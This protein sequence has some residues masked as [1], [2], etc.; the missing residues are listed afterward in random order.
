ML[1]MLDRKA[2]EDPTRRTGPDWAARFLLHAKQAPGRC[3]AVTSLGKAWLP[4]LLGLLTCALVAVAQSEYGAGVTPDGA[5]YYQQSYYYSD[6]LIVPHNEK[7]LYPLLL[8]MGRAVFGLPLDW[9]AAYVNGLTFGLTVGVVALW[10][11]MRGAS[12]LLTAWAGLLCGTS[13]LAFWASYAL[14]ESLCIALATLSLFALDEFLVGGR[15]GNLCLTVATVAAAGVGLTRLSV[16]VPLVG[17]L[18]L[19]LCV[20]TSPGRRRWTLAAAV[21][22]C[23]LAPATA[24]FLFWLVAG[25]ERLPEAFS[26]D[27]AWRSVVREAQRWLLTPTGA[28]RI[29]GGVGSIAGSPDAAWLWSAIGLKTALLCGV[30]FLWGAL[31][32]AV[33][34]RLHPAGVRTYALIATFLAVNSSFAVVLPALVEVSFDAR[35]LATSYAPGLVMAVLVLQGCVGRAAESL[36]AVRAA[37]RPRRAFVALGWCAVLGGLAACQGAKL[38]Q[39]VGD[40][41]D[42]AR[43]HLA[44]GKGYS[45]RRWRQSETMNFLRE[46]V[47]ANAKVVEVMAEENQAVN[48]ALNRLGERDGPRG[49]TVVGMPRGSPEFMRAWFLGH[50]DPAMETYVVWFHDLGQPGWMPERDEKPRR[51][52]SWIGTPGLRI[53][54]AFKDGVVFRLEPAS[55]SEQRDGAEHVLQASSLRDAIQAAVLAGGRRLHSG[56]SFDLYQHNLYSGDRIGSQLIYLFHDCDPLPAGVP[57]F[58]HL[59]PVDVA[60]LPAGRARYGFDNLDHQFADARRYLHPACLAIVDLPAYRVK[61]I[62]TGRSDRRR[63]VEIALGPST[64]P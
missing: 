26:M 64:Q 44:E 53:L 24:W 43:L 31:V 23:A 7:P 11:R 32:V 39:Q 17:V 5:H 15:R 13:V 63:H 54:R 42:G 56:G 6:E 47:P 58:L 10:V 51:L 21:G 55:P 36:A 9:A 34:R 61:A 12:L 2:K 48:Y 62:R 49:Y 29:D 57:V 25:S 4:F 50:G 60:D 45:A 19:F 37:R 35:F 16:A 14:T 18:A 40:T 41:Y 27:S 22:I 20:R 52:L 28:E 8:A 46:T 1:D 33:R 59:V 30:G 3:R 38:H